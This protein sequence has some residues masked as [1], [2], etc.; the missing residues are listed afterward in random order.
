MDATAGPTFLARVRAAMRGERDASALQAMRRAGRGIYEELVLAERD[1]DGLLAGEGQAGEGQ[2][3]DRSP[4]TSSHQVATWVG[5]VLQTIGE[6]LIDA[7]YETRPGTAGY[8]PGPTFQLAE[9]CLAAVPGWLIRAH[10]ARMVSAYDLRR[11]LALP[12]LLPPW[13]TTVSHP[14]THVTALHNASEPI[15]LRAEYGVFALEKSQPAQTPARL[16]QLRYLLADAATTLEYAERLRDPEPD[17]QLTKLM[18]SNLV[19]ALNIWLAVGQLV[20]FPDLVDSY[21]AL[22]RAPAP[23]PTTPRQR[24]PARLPQLRLPQVRP[25]APGTVYRSG[26]AFVA[27]AWPPPSSPAR[28]TSVDELL[29][30]LPKLPFDLRK[31]P[32]GA[33][34]GCADVTMWHRAHGLYAEHPPTSARFCRCGRWLPCTYR[35]LATMG[36]VTAFLCRPGEPW[37]EPLRVLHR[38]VVT[39]A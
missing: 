25:A 2:A 13:I 10:Q 31:P 16:D 22:R 35:M 24:P 17:P 28:L 37:P 4:A 34:P 32:P 19:R 9:W 26:P 12:L 1:I 29:A 30:R 7:D 14:P 11:Q 6:H 18:I 39:G 33:P 36:L 27:L 15:R 38:S 5:F 8:L 20:A 23:R 21:L 3:E